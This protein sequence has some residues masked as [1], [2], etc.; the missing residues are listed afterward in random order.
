MI[1]YFIMMSFCSLFAASCFQRESRQDTLLSQRYLPVRR[2]IKRISENNI[3]KPKN[4]TI[5]YKIGFV[6]GWENYAPFF[7]C[8]I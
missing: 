5:K 4:F 1:L 2:E 6:V 3:F 8:I 7:D